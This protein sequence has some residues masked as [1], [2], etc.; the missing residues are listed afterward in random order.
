MRVPS[1]HGPFEWLCPA[2]TEIMVAGPSH[3]NN[4]IIVNRCRH[5]GRVGSDKITKTSPDTVPQ[6]SVD[7]TTVLE[8]SEA[9]SVTGHP[10]SLAITAPERVTFV[11]GTCREEARWWSDVLSVYPRSKAHLGLID[12]TIYLKRLYHTRFPRYQ[13]NREMAIDRLCRH[14]FPLIR[15]KWVS[16]RKFSEGNLARAQNDS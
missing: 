10:H 14:H 1:I 3:A 8:V 13:Q 15:L 9:D 5:N 16:D 4:C 12:F 6:A 2:T 7:M 11:K